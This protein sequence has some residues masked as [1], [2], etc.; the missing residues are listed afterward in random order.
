VAREFLA[1]G[2][3]ISFS[4]IVTFKSASTLREA[5]SIVPDERLLAETDA[6]FLAPEPYRGKRNEPAFIAR[7]FEVLARLRNVDRDALGAQIAANAAR[8]FQIPAA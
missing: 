4:G 8:L 6:P 7:T 2:F 5:A 1:L 3:H